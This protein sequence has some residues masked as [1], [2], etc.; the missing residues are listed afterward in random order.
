MSKT[1][2]QIKLYNK[3]YFSRPE[4]IARAKIRNAKYRV[5]RALYKKTIQGKK[6]EK[7]YK[8]K[9]ETRSLVEWNRIKNRYGISEKDFDVMLLKQKGSCAICGKKTNQRL[10]IDHCHKTNRVRGLLCGSCNRALGLLKDNTEFLA[11]AIVY[12]NEI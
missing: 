2:E 10:H 9:P 3:E 7:R 4:V 12:L 8:D 6:S 11:Q 5:R 1:K